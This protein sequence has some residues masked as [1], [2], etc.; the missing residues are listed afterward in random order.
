MHCNFRFSYVPS[1][2]DS[3]RISAGI[4]K[5]S[6]YCWHEVVFAEV[7][8]LYVAITRKRIISHFMGKENINI[9]FLLFIFTATLQQ[10]PIVLY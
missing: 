2:L 5:S 1:F 10:L 4:N 9:E 6:F 7:Q 3:I 8:L